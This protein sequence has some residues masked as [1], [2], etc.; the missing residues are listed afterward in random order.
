MQTT[1]LGLAIALI[2]ALLAALI[3]PFFVNWNDHRAFFEAEASRLVGL[4]VQVAGDIDAGILPF[5]LVR[6]AGIAV[7][8]EGEASRLTARSLHIE[9]GLGALMRGEFRA[10]E[11]R[12]VGPTLSLGLDRDGRIDWPAIA[13]DAD[14][15]LI[16]RLRI[17]DGRATLSDAASHSRL[18]LDQVQFEGEVRSF[19]GPIRGRGFF[20]AGGIGYGYNV[21]AG[22]YGMDGM[23]M[24]LDLETAERPEAMEAEGLLSFEGGAPRF[25]GALALARPA[26]TVLATG[27]AVAHE[28]W[29]LT[30]K[31]KT[32]AAS[33]ACWR[34]PACGRDRAD[35]R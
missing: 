8:P 22:R 5:P 26:G 11:M 33:A 32:N 23:R 17:E 27:R 14:A 4:K 35:V 34:S 29:K 2:L 31:V 16:E 9:F 6:L 20:T 7:G 13:L 25:D 3:G 1:L 15:L 30:A 19:A 12:L 28:P 18:V 21:S 10:V 24:R